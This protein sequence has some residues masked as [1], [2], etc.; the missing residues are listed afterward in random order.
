MPAGPASL[1]QAGATMFVRCGGGRQGGMRTWS[2][3]ANGG[4]EPDAWSCLATVLA[5]GVLGI[6]SDASV[7]DLDDLSALVVRCRHGVPVF[8]VG[9]LDVDVTRPRSRPPNRSRARGT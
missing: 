3:E 6:S 4:V 2:K 9:D 7:A 5:G 1:A 8:M